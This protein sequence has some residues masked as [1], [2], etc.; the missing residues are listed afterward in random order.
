MKATYFMDYY[1]AAS[2]FEKTINAGLVFFAVLVVAIVILMLY[3]FGTRNPP[4]ATE[5]QRKK[6]CL[7]CTYIFF[8]EVA[9]VWGAVMT[10]GLFIWSLW[11]FTSYKASDAARLLLPSTDYD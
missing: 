9:N 3:D 1:Q 2:A 6:R 4:G 10:L 8:Y 11:W 7:G 5:E